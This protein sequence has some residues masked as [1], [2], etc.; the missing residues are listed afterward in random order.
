[1]VVSS[2]GT[3]RCKH[4]VRLPK[5]QRKSRHKMWSE[6]RKFVKAVILYEEKGVLTPPATDVDYHH[7]SYVFDYSP[8]PRVGEKSYRSEVYQEILWKMAEID[9]NRDSTHAFMDSVFPYEED[10]E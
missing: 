5:V 9:A 8:S 3:K 1:M 6:L 4:P 7:S 2:G 10:E